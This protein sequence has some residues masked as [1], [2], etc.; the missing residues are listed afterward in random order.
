M[1]KMKLALS[2]IIG[3]AM[4]TSASV[5]QA[6]SKADYEAAKA[7]A[8]QAI[9]KVYEKG[10]LPWNRCP[11]CDV[12]EAA[13]EAAEEGNYAQAVEEAEY[14]RDLQDLAI[15]EWKKQGD[16]VLPQKPLS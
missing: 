16:I 15:E 2:A 7:E 12:F 5:A 10:M 6:A 3:A 8:Q 1:T 9:D 13:D 11:R 14:V 4:V